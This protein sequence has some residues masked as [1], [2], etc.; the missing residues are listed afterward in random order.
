MTFH[1]QF[2]PITILGGMP[3]S[4]NISN[5]EGVLP[6]GRELTICLP[7]LTSHPSYK[8]SFLKP[9]RLNLRIVSP[10]RPEL[11]CDF[12]DPTSDSELVYEV[13]PD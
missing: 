13:E 10:G 4:C 3:P 8:V 11:A 5:L 6:I 1:I 2:C 12:V 7:S 9:S